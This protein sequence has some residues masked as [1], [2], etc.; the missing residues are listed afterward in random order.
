MQRR[1]IFEKGAEGRYG[2]SLPDNGFKGFKLK[3]I[4]KKY[5]RQS[6]L[7]L[8][9]VTE[10]EVIRH[11][12]NLSQ[13]NFGVDSGSYPLGSCTMKY[14]PKINEHIARQDYFTKMH[15]Y[16]PIETIQGSLEL[17]YNLE[18][19][20]CNIFGM[21]AFSLQPAAGAHGEFTGMLIIKAY[22]EKNGDSKRNVV[23]I[24]DN[25]HGTN[26]ASAAMA[27]FS[28]KEVKTD[29]RGNV[30][31]EALKASLDDTVAGLMLTN[32]ST[33]GLFEE[34][35]SE[36]A[37]L[38]HEAGGLLYYDGA[39]AN[40]IM[41]I[42][43]PGDMGFDVMHTNLHKTFATPHGGG[44]PGA[45]PVGVKAFLKDFLPAMRVEKN[46]EE[47]FVLTVPK[48]TIGRVRSYFGNFTVLVKAYCY[49]LTMG[50][51]GLKHA[52]QTAIINAN[53]LM[54]LLKEGGYEVPYDRRCM[55]EFVLS[56]ENIKKE[57]DVKAL[58]I[59]KRLIDMGY[60]PPTMYFPLIVHEAM[61]FEPTETEA[62]EDV[63]ALAKAML[64]IL[65][66]AK[67]NPQMLHDAPLTAPVKRLDDVRA[68]RTP[69]LT[70]KKA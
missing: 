56:T 48:D 33:L 43:R 29:A 28:I 45:G 24:P 18:I 9:Q 63:E 31:I 25:A 69:V 17:M 70:Y 11:Y 16:Q 10:G 39:N 35:I 12:T 5:M 64:D 27:G 67:T 47:E 8:P 42:V 32:P 23:L 36:I 60:H 66:E 65:E 4:S 46:E 55:H 50:P 51:Q 57:Y 7:D 2:Y 19:A 1:L 52:S 38:V 59:A 34:N 20:L 15:P 68:A 22:H 6:E 14:N 37:Q 30:D 53:Y 49:I 40:A 41:G 58:D 61:M 13:L 21:D 26:P 3:Q 44:G 54:A 62:V